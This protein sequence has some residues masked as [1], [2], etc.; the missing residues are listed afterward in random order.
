MRIAL[1]TPPYAEIYGSYRHLYRRG[2]L[3]PPLSLCY[4]AAAL[5][6]ACHSVMLIDSEGENLGIEA[7]ID[8]IR[9]FGPG[10]VGITATSVDFARAE[11]V[12]ARLKTA[13]PQ[14]PILLGGVHMNI[15]RRQVL[16]GNEKI[17]FGAV[18]DG[19]DLIVELAA[20]LEDSRSASLREV[21]GLIHRDG[22]Q[23]VENESRPL[24]ENID[25]YP[26]PARHLLRN[27]L[28]KRSIPR[29]GFRTTA[30]YMSSRGCPFRC[31]FCAVKKVYGGCHV[32]LRSAGNVLEELEL[33]VKKMGI[34]H[35]S[36]NDDCLTLD[37]NRMLD[38]C[39]GI[40]GR[41]LEFSWEGLSRADLVDLELLE[42]MKSAGLV[43]LS[44]GIESGDPE[45][46]RILQKGETLEQI[47]EAFRLCREVGIV[48]RGSVIIGNPYETRETVE[49]TFNFVR[50]LE[51]LDQLV[52]NVLQPYPGTRV[53]EMVLNGEGGARL[54]GED[55]AYER[56]QR[57]GG[58]QVAVND[59]SP[60]DLVAL[61]RQGFRSF[62]FRPRTFWR[63]LRITGLRSFM[64][65]GL[66]FVRSMTRL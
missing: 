35:V 33:I 3:N 58:A 24:E 12:I 20:A 25:R 9:R 5:E 43:R 39:E 48:T 61:Q 19:E 42:A 55:R 28:Y 16:D 66:N 1:I 45:I 63:N 27:D 41:G 54:V 44:F 64:L 6:R 65:D 46:L 15:F 30:A 32:R 10:L 26:L 7:I 37:R 22:G 62:Y 13:S 31:I 21:K 40:R 52:V 60:G 4:L 17:D 18:G 51:G 2:F 50:R 38:I 49:R 23:V 53:R 8:R 56:L 59:L 29:R 34:T 11:V 47:S 36:F 57:F 14:T